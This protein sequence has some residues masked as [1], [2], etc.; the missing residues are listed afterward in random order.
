MLTQAIAALCMGLTASPATTSTLDVRLKKDW[1]V[2]ADYIEACSCSMFCSC[3]FNDHPEGGMKC[4]FNNAV[5]LAEAKVG[6]VKLDGKKFW[7]SGDLGGD[8]T[9]PLKSAV[10]T[11]DIGTNQAE[12]DAIVFL[13]GKIY[14]FQWQSVKMD[15]API[16]WERTGADGYAKLGD[17]GEVKLKGI[18]GPNGKQVVI[19][20]LKYWGAMKCDGFELAYGTHHYKGNGHNYSHENRNG[21]FV[22]IESSGTD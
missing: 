19:H 12:K 1:S 3:Y 16:T 17:K 21:F 15:E 13:I 8:F 11:F 6:D 7:L 9:K 4:E 18:L 14:P 5:R 10:I 20:N 2:K 22:H